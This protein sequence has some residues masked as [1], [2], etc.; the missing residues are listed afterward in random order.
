MII[1]VF[2]IVLFAF[3]H[4]MTK[5]DFCICKSKGGDQ[6]CGN[7]A[8]EQHLCFCYIECTI[9]LLSESETSSLLSNDLQWLYSLVCVD[10]VGYPEDRSETPKTGYLK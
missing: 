4:K 3:D 10:L 9:P 7:H 8:V 5:S 1:I 6:L 2:T